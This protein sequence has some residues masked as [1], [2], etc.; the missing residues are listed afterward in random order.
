[1]RHKSPSPAPSS[2]RRSGFPADM[3]FVARHR[4]LLIQ[5]TFPISA[6]IA[7][8]SCRPRSA[9]GSSAGRWSRI[10]LLMTLPIAIFRRRA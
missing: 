7:R 6:F 2:I 8:R 9:D 1:L 10:S 4:A 3:C 5:R